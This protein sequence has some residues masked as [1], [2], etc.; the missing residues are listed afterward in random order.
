MDGNLGHGGLYAHTRPGLCERGVNVC[1]RGVNMCE[2]GVNV[3][4]RGVNV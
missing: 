3:C 4:G 1:G 2:R